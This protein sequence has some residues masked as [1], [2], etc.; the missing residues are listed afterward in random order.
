MTPEERAKFILEMFINGESELRAP[1]N[2]KL[3]SI[4]IRRAEREAR[5]RALEEAARLI[6]TYPIVTTHLRDAVAAA[7]RKL[8]EEA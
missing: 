1:F 2:Q 5:K 3:I 4:E 6:E 7:I 8:A